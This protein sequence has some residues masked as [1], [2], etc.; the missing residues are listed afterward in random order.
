MKRLLQH[1]GKWEKPDEID[2]GGSPSQDLRGNHLLQDSFL[3]ETRE[4]GSGEFP[5][6]PDFLE[7]PANYNET[8]GWRSRRHRYDPAG[9]DG[10]AGSGALQMGCVRG[11]GPA[12]SSI[13]ACC[14]ASACENAAWYAPICS[15]LKS[16]ID[17]GASK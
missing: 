8:T 3:L 14:T 7:F 5:G 13:G 6:K 15:M 12:V 9:Y 16:R 2:S 10:C 11:I 4:T 17:W 1:E